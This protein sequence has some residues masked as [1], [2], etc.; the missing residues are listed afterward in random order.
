[1]AAQPSCRPIERPLRSTAAAE[2]LGYA[3]KYVGWGGDGR[4]RP[5]QL[6]AELAA[7]VVGALHDAARAV[8]ARWPTSGAWR[9]S[10]SSP[11]ASVLFVNE[12]N[13]VPG[14]LARYLWVDPPVPFIDLLDALI[15]EAL[16]R[17]AGALQRGRRRRHRAA[18][19]RGHRRQAGL[20]PERPLLAAARMPR[21]A[22]RRGDT[23][24]GMPFPRRL[25]TEDEEVVVEIR[26]HWAFLGRP[27]VVA[28]GVV[29]LSIAVM[30]VFSNAPP[31]VLY[32]LLVLVACSAL[33][34]VGRLVRWFATSLVVTTTRIVQRSGVFGRTGL[35]LRL[36][37]VNQLSYH[38]SISDRILRTGELHVEMGGETGVVVFDRV[39][40][41]AAVQSIITEQ[42][43]A[44]RHRSARP[45]LDR[46]GRGSWRRERG[47]PP[48]GGQRCGHDRRDPAVGHRR[49][50][51]VP[52]PARTPWR[53]ASC[54]S[55]SSGA[56]ASSP[57]RSSPPRKPSC[58]TVCD[59]GSGAVSAGGRRRRARTRHAGV[60]QERRGRAHRAR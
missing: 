59:R 17:P 55:T 10:T 39:P 20:S 18:R 27:L 4:A 45:G 24:V 33:W 36:E 53:T 50:C 54:S 19:R 8:R 46:A 25:L 41:P 42:I 40:R 56:G 51:R 34:L 49:G 37:R 31:A 21:D 52:P 32:M 13:T 48:P 14:S 30:V 47:R 26:P 16:A 43:D 23:L 15:G 58:S 3:D 12:V 2:I 9:A 35:E 6:P 1:M 38:Q 5:R 7:P 60:A 57:T 28:V 29:A 44:L 11:T 22:D